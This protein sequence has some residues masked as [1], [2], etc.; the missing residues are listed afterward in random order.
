MYQILLVLLQTNEICP[1]GWKPDIMGI[2]YLFDL[3]A[4][5]CTVVP[6]S[7]LYLVSSVAVK[8]NINPC[9]YI[10]EVAED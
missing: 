8:D 1:E 9:T 10:T 2:N 3:Q 4:F 6:S 7:T 5:G